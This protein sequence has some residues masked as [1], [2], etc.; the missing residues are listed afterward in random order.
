MAAF[1]N[2][3]SLP[4]QSISPPQVSIVDIFLPGFAGISPAIQQLLA[5]NLNSYA[6][7]LCVCGTLMFLCRH[8]YEYLWG[9]VDKFLSL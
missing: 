4:I 6:G 1:N 3:S 9:F 7:V 5:G 8:V 2:A